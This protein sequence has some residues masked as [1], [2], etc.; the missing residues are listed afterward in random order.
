MACLPARFGL[1]RM[2]RGMR[3]GGE[4]NTA[5]ECRHHV[6]GTPRDIADDA[7][8]QVDTPV[9]LRHRLAGLWHGDAGRGHQA[10]RFRPL[11]HR[12]ETDPRHHSAA[13]P[14]RLGRG[15]RQVQAFAGIRA[16]QQGHEPRR[17]QAHLLVGMGAPLPRP[18]RRLRLFSCRWCS[19]GRRD[20]S[21][22]GSSPVSSRSSPWAAFRAPSAGGWS[23]QASSTGSMSASTGSRCI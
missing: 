2:A 9:A 23:P 20:A 14:V 4:E 8:S 7:Q 10:H 15:I 1:G 13:Q 22:R 16:R 19:S 5:H 12:V 6:D 17:I 11:H 21:S 18:L 3:L